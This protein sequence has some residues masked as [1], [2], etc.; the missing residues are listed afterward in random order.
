MVVSLT[1]VPRRTVLYAAKLAA[2]MTTAAAGAFLSALAA[3]VVVLAVTPHGAH[4]LGDPATL[5]SV[6]L[7]VVAVTAVGVAVGIITRSPT[8]SIAVVFVAVLLPKAAGGLLGGLQPWVVGASPG[9]VITQLVGSSQLGS[10]QAYPPG[11]LAATA[12]MLA[13]AA[14]VAAGGAY[15]LLRRDG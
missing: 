14:A 4:R 12:T 1:T 13:V 15:A 3:F 9:T 6:V 7:A 10:S 2:A 8:A 11:P 5:L